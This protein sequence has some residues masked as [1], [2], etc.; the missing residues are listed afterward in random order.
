AGTLAAFADRLA[1]FLQRGAIEILADGPVRRR[2]AGQDEIATGSLHGLGDW[3]TGEQV[4]AE[5]HW[6]RSIQRSAMPGQPA[7]G[8]VALAILLLRAVLR[9]DELR[10]QRQHMLVSR[11]DDA[12]AEEGME[13]LGAAVG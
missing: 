3:L 5:K 11:R 1:M 12:G 6:P 13:I 4:V 7:F 9:H 8:R 2:L 10:R